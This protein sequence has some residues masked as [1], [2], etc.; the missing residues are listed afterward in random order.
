MCNIWIYR[1]EG[2]NYSDNLKQGILLVGCTKYHKRDWV[3]QITKYRGSGHLLHWNPKQLFLG[4]FISGFL[5]SSIHTAIAYTCDSSFKTIQCKRDAK[6]KSI[7]G[8]PM[9]KEMNQPYLHQLCLWHPL[10]LTMDLQQEL[11]HHLNGF[12]RHN[13]LQ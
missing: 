12:H 13:L 5:Y 4:F 7:D 6:F 2:R 8:P 10:Q 11:I 3:W 9:D 1:K